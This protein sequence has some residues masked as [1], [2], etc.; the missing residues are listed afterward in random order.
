MALVMGVPAQAHAE[1]PEVEMQSVEQQLD[2]PKITVEGNIIQVSNA[3]GKYLVVYDLTG[4][5][6]RRV[7]IDGDDR[8]FD[9]SLEPGACYIIKVDKVVRKVAIAKA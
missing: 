3:N 6:V 2:Q 5:M 7:K 8:R 1:T 9:L 4:K